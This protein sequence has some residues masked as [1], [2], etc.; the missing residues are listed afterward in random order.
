MKNLL[1]L[2]SIVLIIPASWAQ[3]KEEQ[4]EKQITGIVYA[5]GNKPFP[6][7]DIAKIGNYPSVKTDENGEYTI[8]AKATDTLVF[9]YEGYYPSLALVSNNSAIAVYLQEELSQ[10]RTKAIEGALGMKKDPLSITY[11]EDVVEQTELLRGRNPNTIEALNG[12]VSG[13]T[14]RY[15][16]AG[17]PNSIN[18]RGNRTIRGGNDA[19]I[20]I[21]GVI[22]NYQVL[23]TLDNNIIESITVN[24][25]ASGAALYGSQGSNGV[26]LVKTKK[27]AKSK[28]QLNSQA[29][30]DETVPRYSKRL[31]VNYKES[32][33][34]YIE[35]LASVEDAYSQYQANKNNFWGHSAYFVDMYEYFN[36]NGKSAYSQQVFDDVI[37]SDKADYATLRSLAYYLES[38]GNFVHAN[39][40]YNKVLNFKSDDAKSYRHM[41]LINQELGK[42]QIAFNTLNVVVDNDYMYNQGIYNASKIKNIALHEL[43]NLLQTDTAVN[44]EELIGVNEINTTFDLRIVVDA[45]RD[46]VNLNIKVVE[47]YL[48]ISSAEN[49]TTR[50]GGE[51][52]V[53]EGLSEY[54]LRNARKGS[55]YIVADYSQNPEEVVTFVKVTV[56]KNYGK[57][58]ATKEVKMI[59]L[60]NNK[61]EQIIEEIK[62]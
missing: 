19:L 40:A 15:D 43:N 10:K 53:L 59:R 18:I 17:N 41:A 4:K 56:Y 54:S 57:P 22:S 51:M 9:T 42:N 61:K 30:N 14:V 26:I 8:L 23:S 25:G 34:N 37:N 50:I 58:N 55:Y 36:E 38:E 29:Y 16:G 48:E 60:T 33:P 1:L 3:E 31:K 5:T 39:I 11:S 27:S 62:F 21:D 12:K 24:K 13:L 6:G 35:D 47:P 20:V 52:N 28:S 49:E 45:N 32:T 44:T 46:D 2:L 7:V